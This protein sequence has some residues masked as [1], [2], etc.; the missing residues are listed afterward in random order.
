MIVDDTSG[1][2]LANHQRYLDPID[3]GSG[4]PFEPVHVATQCNYVYTPEGWTGTLP[5][6]YAPIGLRWPNE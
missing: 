4:D 3:M 2:L 1:V 6:P 5:E